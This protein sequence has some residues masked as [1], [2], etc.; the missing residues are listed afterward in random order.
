LKENDPERALPL[1]KKAV[2]L[3]NDLRIAYLDMG[4]ILT[5]QKKYSE[6]L[7]AL[8][9]AEKLDPSQPDAHY[10]LGRIY[11]QIGNS[12]ASQKEFAKVRE[13][14]EKDQGDIVHQ[15]SDFPP[16]LKP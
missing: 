10:R 8:Q 16:P 4:A 2:E 3:K 1:L 15:M 12:A 14:H 7:A 6:A 11:K 13:L 5:N 9:R